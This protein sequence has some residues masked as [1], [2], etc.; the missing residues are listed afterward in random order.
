MLHCFTLSDI[1]GLINDNNGQLTPRVKQCDIN[2]QPTM[3][4]AYHIKECECDLIRLYWRV[5]FG[6]QDS[7]CNMWLYAE[8]PF[9][10]FFFISMQFYHFRLPPSSSVSLCSSKFVQIFTTGWYFGIPN[11]GQ[12]WVLHHFWKY[13]LS[14][15]DCK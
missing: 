2:S 12:C 5:I 7:I 13:P 6:S 10:I 8:N 14:Y 15:V 3:T 11:L 9:T 1:E 4:T